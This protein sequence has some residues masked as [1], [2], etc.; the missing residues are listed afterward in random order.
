MLVAMIRRA[1]QPGCKFDQIIVLESKEG[2]RKST[3]LHVL[4]GGDANFSD[5]TA[6]RT[7]SSKNCCAAFGSM[8]SPT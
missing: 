3:A 8:K 4:A 2:T 1:K 6:K 7:K 5:Q